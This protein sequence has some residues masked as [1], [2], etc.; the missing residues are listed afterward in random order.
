MTVLADQ[1][2]LFLA[3]TG[4]SGPAVR[5]LGLD[6]GLCF[7]GRA[8]TVMHP[9]LSGSLPN[10]INALKISVMT[11]PNLNIPRDRIA[12]F[13]RKNHI[14]RLSLFGS[15]LRDDFRPD[16]DVDVLVEFEP[17]VRVGLRFF[18]IERELSEILGRQVDLNTPGF[19]SSEILARAKAEALVQ[20]DAA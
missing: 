1:K 6:L 7:P 4:S 11:S 19:L 2:S 20:Y 17:S 12:E 8:S 18:A 14:R 10:G 9:S 16:S 3:K 13:C 15:V 5:R